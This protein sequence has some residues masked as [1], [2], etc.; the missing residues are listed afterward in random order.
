MHFL[1]M[2]N[3]LV[4]AQLEPIEEIKNVFLNIGRHHRSTVSAEFSR[5]PR[6][7]RG[8]IKYL[9]DGPSHLIVRSKS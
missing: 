8:R 6:L 1:L 4:I 7:T 2:D 3:R 9:K 5:I